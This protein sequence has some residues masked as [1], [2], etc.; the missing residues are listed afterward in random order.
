MT[1]TRLQVLAHHRLIGLLPCSR[2][3]PPRRHPLQSFSIVPSLCTM[4]EA[5]E[6]FDLVN[7]CE[8][9]DDDTESLQAIEMN[10][11]LVRL[12]VLY[13][14]KY[15]PRCSSACVPRASHLLAHT[16][17]CCTLCVSRFVRLVLGCCS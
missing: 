5:M 15:A 17:L 16:T 14:P 8:D 4:E 6:V 10:E 11:A 9:S 13:G 1:H 12:A 7:N 3:S 2:A